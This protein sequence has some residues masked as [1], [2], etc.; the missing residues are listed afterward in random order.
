MTETLLSYRPLLEP[1]GLLAAGVLLLTAVLLQLRATRHLRGPQRLVLM[2]TR[3]T[4]AAL[5]AWVLAG[6][7]E[8]TVERTAGEEEVVIL[9]D[10]SRSMSIE[11]DGGTR[12]ELAVADVVEP[13]AAAIAAAVETAV[14]TAVA[15]AIRTGKQEILGPSHRRQ[16]ETLRVS[17]NPLHFL[18]PWRSVQRAP[19][20]KTPINTTC[21]Q[22]YLSKPE[23]LI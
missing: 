10:V 21:R 5:L 7:L 2:G 17:P 9:L 18:I 19:I 11:A 14:E 3:A 12:L 13:L 23:L 22:S 6:P 1:W 16:L 15:T 8:T 4:A 20:N